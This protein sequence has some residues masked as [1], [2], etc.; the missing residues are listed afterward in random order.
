[1]RRARFTVGLPTF[2]QPVALPERSY[3][4]EVLYWVLRLF[5]S[6]R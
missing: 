5:S 2:L 4:E 3:L 6:A 1:M